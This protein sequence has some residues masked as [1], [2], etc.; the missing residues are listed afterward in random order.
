MRSGIR[1]RMRR[2][3]WRS[4]GASNSDARESLRDGGLEFHRHYAGSTACVPSRATLFTGQYPSLH[5]VSQTDGIAKKN[6]DPGDGLVGPE[7]GADV[8]RLVPCRWLPDALSRASGTCRTPTSSCP[9]RTTR[10]WPPTTT[11][12]RS[13]RRSTSYRK[14]D[15]LDPFGF[16][17]WIGREP[18]GAAK[19][20][21]GAVR[22]GV[23]AEQVVELFG[24]LARRAP[25]WSVARGRV[26]RESA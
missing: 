15:R 7:L 20:D 24:E 9:A 4:S 25:G 23:F 22:D 13:S 1:R 2:T 11:A 10:S 14:A 16:S 6:T 3:R 21:C 5:G 8:G 26:V 18:H 17:G 19:C 12:T